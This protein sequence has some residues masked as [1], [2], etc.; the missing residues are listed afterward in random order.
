MFYGGGE[1]LNWAVEPKENKM[2]N[3]NRVA[4]F[5]SRR[6]QVVCGL[7]QAYKMFIY[8]FC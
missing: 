4:N 8:F 7:Y 2:R 3:C 6:Q 1:G 5:D